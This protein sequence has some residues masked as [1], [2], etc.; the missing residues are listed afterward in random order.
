MKGLWP[1]TFW[2][3]PSWAL[4]ASMR[5]VWVISLVVKIEAWK[6]IS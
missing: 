5:G 6:L 2:A 4:C 3:I 1:F